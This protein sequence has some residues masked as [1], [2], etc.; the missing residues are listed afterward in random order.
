LELTGAEILLK[1]LELEGVD[2]IF[3]YPGGAVLPIYDALPKFRLNHY[4]VRHEQGAAHAAEGYARSTGKV[5]VCLATSGPGAT[6]LVT[7]I[8]NAYMDSIP[9]VAITGQVGCQSLGLDTFQEI[10]ITGITLPITKHSYLVKKVENLGR[11]IKEAFYIARSGRPGPVLIDIPKD[12]LLARS[13]FHHS[14]KV[15]IKS[16]KVFTK[17]NAN[18]IAEA[19][20]TL[21][22]AKKPLILAGGGVINAG[23]MPELF[24]LVE[25]TGIP[26]VSTLM[27][28]GA[29]PAGS[30]EWLGMLGMH[31]T[32]TANYAVNN[33]DVLLAVGARFDNRVTLSRPEEMA[34]NAAI[35]HIDVDP[36]EI[37]KIIQ[38]K[39][40]IVGDAKYIL[41]ELLEKVSKPEIH[42]WLEQI[43]L[44]R[45]DF[46][47]RYTAE[48]VL[49]PQ[50][51]IQ[52]LSEVTSENAIVATDVGQH[53]MWTAQYYRFNKARTMITAGALGPMGFGLP[54]AIGAQ[55]G[56]P[57]S[58]VVLV[59]GDGSIQMN[60]Q[61]LSTI[62][63]YKL[64]VKVI[65]LNN[66][67][68]GLVRQL[69]E[70][71]HDKRYS[72]IH[73]VANPDFVKLAE[74]YGIKGYRVTDP[75]QVR[76]VL[77]EGIAHPGPV[78]MEFVV[79]LEENVYP[80]VPEG[81]VITEMLGR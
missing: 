47:L 32:V 77:A 5:G 29:F 44:W 16:Y 11:V 25:K 57:D 7:G 72:Q 42:P 8:A 4:L 27:G 35:I 70:T 2:V 74:A 15:N 58:T 41:A 40:P 64:P 24:N 69:Q 46:P 43:S 52:Q 56:N 48:G 53:Q 10:D 3:G 17:G 81:Q 28:I 51:V 45:K 13:E 76:K 78:V 54:A 20:V 26:V 65:I 71:F 67:A 9:M 49:K 19:A 55:L 68:L 66:G 73:L 12:V 33:C 23:A 79:P 21:S 30:G 34:P 38:P 75:S 36:A 18:K 14:D 62:V 39:V 80:F 1:S 60:I 6:N 61:E 50:F 22:K 63:Q 37:G 59:S 31:G